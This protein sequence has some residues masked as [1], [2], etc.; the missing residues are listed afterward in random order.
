MQIEPYLHLLMPAI[1]TCLV[2]KR[3]CAS[4]LENHWLLRDF[5][6]ALLARVCRRF[7]ASY[8]SLQPRVTKTLSRALLDPARY[9]ARARESARDG[10]GEEAAFFPCL[11]FRLTIVLVVLFFCFCFVLLFARS[12]M[13]RFSSFS[14]HTSSSSAVPPVCG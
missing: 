2:G 13:P 14:S 3:L 7:G 9:T 11:P 6:A 5:C 1:L 4:P 12:F 10:T 8:D